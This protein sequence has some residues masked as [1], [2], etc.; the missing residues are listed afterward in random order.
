MAVSAQ[1]PAVI[2]VMVYC[3]DCELA[4]VINPFIVAISNPA[5]E[6]EK[7]PIGLVTVGIIIP[8]VE[9]YEELA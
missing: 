1:F 6:E 2:C 7:L 5:G 4:V 9:Q 8:S 3:P